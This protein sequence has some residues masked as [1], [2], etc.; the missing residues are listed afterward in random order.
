MTASADRLVIREARIGDLDVIAA[1]NAQLA[2]ET[3][4]KTLDLRILSRGVA[5]ALDDPDRLRYWVATR[6][7]RP[8]GQAAV[9]REWS[10]WRCGWVWWFQSVYIEPESRGQGVF[11]ALHA[12]IRN[13][14]LAN[15][16]VI[17]LR[18]YVEAENVK[19]QRTYQALGMVPGGYHVY[20]ELWRERFNAAPG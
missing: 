8:V 19:A 4:A 18:L 20:E 13:E 15:P 14:A 10:D 16:S 3:E 12:R 9:T 7:G 5:L 1:F 6:D 2:F 17:G 11:R